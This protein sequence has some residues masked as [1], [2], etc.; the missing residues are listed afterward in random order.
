M[1]MTPEERQAAETARAALHHL[2]E[3]YGA[4]RARAGERDVKAPQRTAAQLQWWQEHVNRLW[5]E[6]GR[7]RRNEADEVACDTCKGARYVSVR[8]TV[9]PR[10]VPCPA[11]WHEWYGAQIR[12]QWPLTDHERALSE[13]KFRRRQDAP[14]MGEV[15]HRVSAFADRVID[16]SADM[17]AITGAVGIG[18]THLMLALYRKVDAHNRAVIYR[19]ATVIQRH[20][21]NFGYDPESRRMADQRREM[22]LNALTRVPLLILDE[23]EKAT[24]EW[25]ENQMLDIINIRRNNRLATALAGNDL[26]RLPAPVLSRAQAAGCEFI[27]LNDVPDARPVLEIP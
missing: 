3:Q 6:G 25:F 20:L 26:Y 7:Q 24:G 5:E 2:Q 4:E 14:Q 23:A 13:K 12:R 15:A 18:K 1:S 16:G 21:Q 9:P 11:C 10:T 17:L 19:T 27:A 8:D 22:A